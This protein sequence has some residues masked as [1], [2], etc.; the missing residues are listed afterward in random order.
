MSLT[1][2]DT[3][4]KDWLKEF[5]SDF[6]TVQIEYQ[7]SAAVRYVDVYFEP[8]L[9]ALPAPMGIFGRMIEAPCLLEP[10][11]NPIPIAE[12]SNCNSKSTILGHTLMRQA[13]LE[14]RDFRFE[15]RPFLWMI[16]PTLSAYI[17]RGFC[18]HE[19]PDWVPGIYF[20]PE[21]ERSAIIAVHQLPATLDTL[22]LRLLG[23]GRVQKRAIQELMAL[24]KAHPYRQSTLRHIAV[25]QKNLQARENLTNDLRG[26]IMTLSITY[27]QI[28]AE[29]RQ[30]GRQEGRQE[31]A[32]SLILRQLQHRFRD[33]VTEAVRSRLTT[34]SLDQLEL[35]SE[36][37]LDFSSS[38]DL[39][40]WFDQVHPA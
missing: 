4:A 24:P 12:I 36:D 22:W 17:Y 23:R 11:R 35:L 3:F 1:V 34:L 6:G 32:L 40:A 30:E 39:A 26:V 29:I 15:Q 7:I 14:E 33:E 8:N 25:L 16:S 20:L 18:G 19:R 10:F 31:E 2:H 27:E 28:E 9:A 37:L 13:N 21:H 5:L 38:E